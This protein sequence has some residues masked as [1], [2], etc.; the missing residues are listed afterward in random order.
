[1]KIL[2]WKPRGERLFARKEGAAPGSGGWLAGWWTR[3]MDALVARRARGRATPADK[4]LVVSVGNLALGGT[5]KTPVIMKLA[6][7]L[8]EAGWLGVVL[9]RGF[10]S[11][12]A[13]PLVVDSREVR[14]GDEARLMASAL[15]D[16]GWQVIQSRRRDRG[17]ELAL[18]LPHPPR[19]V[20]LEDGHQTGGV[21]RHLDVLLLDSWSL[22]ESN[23]LRVVCPVAG[24]VVPFGPYRESSRGARRARIWLLETHD[25]VPDR[26]AQG[27]RVVTFTRRQ[28]LEPAVAGPQVDLPEPEHCA[29]LSGIARPQPF[30]EGVAR[31]LGG[32]PGLAVRFGDHQ[33]YD[34][35]MV[36]RIGREMDSA[37]VTHLVTTEKDW[38][39]LQP[40]WPADRS[41]WLARL[42]IH[43][44][45][46]ASLPGL[47]RE[48]GPGCVSDQEGA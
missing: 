3:Q 35:G 40:M 30:E 45:R 43:W 41:A 42:E 47:I 21:G 37:G 32:E 36:D 1:M 48:L 15:A 11:S 7:D 28:I 39:K 29:V 34:A 20:L 14:A 10:K 5:G 22:Q 23:G 13:G 46:G 31:L 26:G 8:A 38:V 4:P 27:Q 33:A 18:D 25:Q 2:D 16:I 6:R 19:V 24:P 17:L 44:G 9:T 12:L